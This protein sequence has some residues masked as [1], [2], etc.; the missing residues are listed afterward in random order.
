[1][2]GREREK[3]LNAILYFV[4]NTDYCHKLKVL[5]L[6]YF[7]DFI[8]FKQTGRSVTGLD[9]EAWRKGPVPPSIFRELE[10]DKNPNDFKEYFFIE[11]EEFSNG[12]G[13]CLKILPRKK[14][15]KKIFTKRELE[16]LE[17]IAFI[18]KEA[19]SDDMSES[20]HLKN[21]PWDKTIKSKGESELI[22]YSLALD[23]QK[24]SLD[25]DILNDRIKIDKEFKE[26]FG[27]K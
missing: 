22:D 2:I 3:L 12:M 11:Y 20:T 5:K 24:D 10:P 18:F 1:M 25:F 27:E 15:N 14:F 19:K 23:D 9:Y 7:L 16:L 13:K 17:Q 4:K 8:H 26:L 21:M 6:L